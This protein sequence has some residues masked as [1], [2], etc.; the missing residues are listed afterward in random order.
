MEI[1]PFNS[2]FQVNVASDV[3]LD[4]W[5]GAKDFANTADFSQYLTTKG[6][7]MEYG[8]EYF[9]EHFASNRHFPT[10]APIVVSESM[11]SNSGTENTSNNGNTNDD[12]D[13]I[14]E[15]NGG[16]NPDLDLNKAEEEVFVE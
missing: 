1:R 15:E 8:G 6:D 9:K 14:A 5:R 16:D 4:G 10:P 2:Q 13:L 7:Y 11:Q 12:K 3:R